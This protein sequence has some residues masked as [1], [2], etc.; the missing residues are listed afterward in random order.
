MRPPFTAEQFFDIFHQ[1]NL[2]VWPIQI[3]LVAVAMVLVAL[4]LASPRSSRVVIAGLAALWVWMA[5]AY[6]FAFFADLTPAAYLFAAVF[7]VEA[8][9]LGW[10][11]LR[12]RRLHFAV[13]REP[14]MT[15]VGAAL[16]AFALVGYPA[17]AYAL[18]QQYP[19]V[20]TFGLPCPT[21]IFTC[22]LLAW[23]VRPVPRS[24]LLIPAAWALLGTTAAI[25]F[26]VRQDF[27]L[28]PAAIIALGFML[29]PRKPR[30]QHAAKTDRP[31]ELGF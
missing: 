28:L 13:K 22:G 20:P 26:G 19:G 18:G 31:F 25:D 2:S 10:H 3:V 14:A 12:T 27:A 7:L 9:L 4:A 8:A 21:V 15:I 30:T 11:G 17:I 24:V 1:Y 5:L 23:C 29:W 16:I 6:H